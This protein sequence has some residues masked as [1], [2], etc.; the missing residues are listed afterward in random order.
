MFEVVNL[1]TQLLKISK[2]MA[3]GSM[4]FKLTLK[5]EDIDFV[6]FSSQDKEVIPKY[7]R[8]V[9]KKSPSQMKQDFRKW[10]L[11]LEKKLNKYNSKPFEENNTKTKIS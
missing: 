10:R 2:Q 7:P 6:D 8:H 4:S 3:A 9:K 1:T 5:T 11:Y